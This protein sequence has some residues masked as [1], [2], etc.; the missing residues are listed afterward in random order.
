[1][2]DCGDGACGAL[3]KI[4]NPMIRRLA[5]ALVVKQWRS[6]IALGCMLLHSGLPKPE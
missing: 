4:V 5:R 3:A 2:N 6:I 1:M